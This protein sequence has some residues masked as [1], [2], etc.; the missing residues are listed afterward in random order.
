MSLVALLL[1]TPPTMERRPGF[2]ATR[3]LQDVLGALKNTLH[4]MLHLPPAASTAAQQIDNLQYLEFAVLWVIGGMSILL[5]LWIM[6]RFRRRGAVAFPPSPKIEA[7]AWLELGTGGFIL[8][9]FLFFWV[10]GFRQ[11]VGVEEPPSDALTVYVT[12]RQWV[13][14]FAYEDGPTSAGV[15]YLP[16]NRPI[17]FLITSRDVI[18]SFYV[19]AFRVKQDA[20]PGRYTTITVTPDTTG[21]FQL[22]CAEYCGAGHSRMWGEVDVL[23]PDRFEAWLDGQTPADERPDSTTAITSP[24]GGPPERMGMA[25]RGFVAAAQ[26]GCLRCHSTDGSPN[27]GP[28]WKGLYLSRVQLQDG[29]TVVAD[30]AYLTRSMMEP[31]VDVVNGFGDVM[32]S[33]Q[34]L[35]PPPDASAIVEYIQSLGG[36]PDTFRGRGSGRNPN[37]PDSTAAGLRLERQQ[38]ADTAASRTPQGP[39]ERP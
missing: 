37:G 20:V 13:W 21:R 34:G 17:R 33:F 4:W 19:P 7:P 18:H 14:K 26:N 32:P 36:P 15:L 22:L 8:A 1:Q 27:I 23:E 5:W 9:L 39:G 6:F 28:T 30:P 29:R 10:L 35:L 3:P 2:E 38:N 25:Q 12:A 11:Y 31:S 24:E 16:V